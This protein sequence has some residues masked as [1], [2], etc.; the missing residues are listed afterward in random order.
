MEKTGQNFESVR[1]VERDRV[2]FIEAIKNFE[3]KEIDTDF[4]EK[5]VAALVSELEK[6]KLFILGEMHGVKENVDIIYTLFKKFGFRKL[7]LE[8]N[9]IMKEKTNEFLQTGELDFESIENIPDGRITAGHFALLK[10]LKEEGLL[11]SLTCFVEKRESRDWDISDR[12]RANK[13]LEDLS[14]AFTLVVAG[15]WHTETKPITFPG[16]EVVHHPMGENIKKH[17]SNVP[18][19]RIEYQKGQYHNFGVK[20]FWVNPDEP[21][22]LKAKFYKTT[23]GIYSFDLPEAHTAVVPNPSE[24]G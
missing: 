15:N 13:V 3:V 8:W 1:N 17:I 14:D 16:E 22:L 7:A 6:S 9:V 21:E 19:G 24:R 18:S 10:R 5:S 23:D 4:D 12:N 11:E 20:D 2:A